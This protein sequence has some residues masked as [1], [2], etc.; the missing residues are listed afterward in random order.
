[1]TKK[2]LSKWWV[3]ILLWG[4][5]AC[6]TLLV[7]LLPSPLILNSTAA[8]TNPPHRVTMHDDAGE[9]FVVTFYDGW[10]KVETEPC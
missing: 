1:M 10:Q 2:W 4:V 8:L 5:A 9:C 3:V 6:L 7:T